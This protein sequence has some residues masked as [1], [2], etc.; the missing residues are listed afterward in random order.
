MD[1]VEIKTDG[2]QTFRCDVFAE[3]HVGL[4]AAMG[5]EERKIVGGSCTL[6]GKFFSECMS[7]L[8]S[9]VSLDIGNNQSEEGGGDRSR[10]S[11]EGV[12]EEEKY[13]SE[14][15]ILVPIISAAVAVVVICIIAAFIICK[16][17][18]KKEK[19]KQVG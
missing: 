11:N 3:L 14:G 16:T 17:C 4:S 9:T 10:T 8:K 18:C 5:K 7:F 1:W 15:E 6:T 13:D 12:V 19:Y 2:D